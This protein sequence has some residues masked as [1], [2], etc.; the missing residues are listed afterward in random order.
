M[1]RVRIAQIGVAQP[2]AAGYRETLMHMPE[3]E[4][5]AAYDP[6]PDAARAELQKVE[7]RMP[8]LRR[9]RRAA[10]PANGRKWC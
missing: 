10:G 1:E 8:A 7:T 9:H 5:V 6:N 4:I 2:H 3:I